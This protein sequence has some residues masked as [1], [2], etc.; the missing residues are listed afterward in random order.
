VLDHL[1][2]LLYVAHLS[3]SHRQSTLSVML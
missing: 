2:Q 3:P 1:L